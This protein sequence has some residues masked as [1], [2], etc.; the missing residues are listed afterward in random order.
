MYKSE[1][2]L[3][4][5]YAETDQMGYCYYGNYAQYFEVARVESLRSLGVAYKDL[6]DMG[7]ILP[8]THFQIKYLKPAFYDENL[9]VK[10][11]IVKLPSA[12]IFLNMRRT[13]KK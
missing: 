2:K 3:R 5:R 4:V 10:S 8:V 11:Y 1:V 9:S 6:E 13:I 12:R 7:I